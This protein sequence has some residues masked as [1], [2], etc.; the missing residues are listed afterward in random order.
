MYEAAIRHGS[1]CPYLGGVEA[2]G[3]EDG[4]QLLGVDGPVPVLV[5]D[6]KGVPEAVMLIRKNYCTDPAILHTDPGPDPDPR[7]Q[8]SIPTFSPKFCFYKMYFCFYLI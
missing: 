4:A 3:P 8:F 5:E 1:S 6:N 2:H 7:K